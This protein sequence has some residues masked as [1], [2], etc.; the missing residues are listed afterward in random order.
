MDENVSE[1]KK[2][3]ENASDKSVIGL[4]VRNPTQTDRSKHENLLAPV[5]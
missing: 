4:K 3:K 5:T 1:K 2:K